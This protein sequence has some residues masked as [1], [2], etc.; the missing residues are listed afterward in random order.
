M[1]NPED[2]VNA[3]LSVM[4]QVSISETWEILLRLKNAIIGGQL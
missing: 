1:R 3:L 4:D 2:P